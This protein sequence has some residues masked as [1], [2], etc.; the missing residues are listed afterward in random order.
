MRRHCWAWAGKEMCV[1]EDLRETGRFSC[2]G[3]EKGVSGGRHN[4]CKS[5]DTWG[6]WVL[7]CQVLLWCSHRRGCDQRSVVERYILCL[8]KRFL[9]CQRRQTQELYP[10][11][12]WQEVLEPSWRAPV[13]LWGRG[14]ACMR[15]LVSWMSWG[16]ALSS[17]KWCSSSWRECTLP[18][19]WNL[20]LGTKNYLFFDWVLHFRG[21]VAK[22]QRAGK[23]CWIYA[24][25][26]FGVVQRPSCSGL[27]T[28]HIPDLSAV[29]THAVS[30]F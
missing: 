1:D 9:R 22:E 11:V 16:R 20:W 17:S 28:F 29:S 26:N 15:P 2:Q 30:V 10:N 7:E 21:R 23:S 13:T 3:V 14:E 5:L 18:P 12:W 4:L 19:F 24:V 8:S 27:N 25:G 6:V